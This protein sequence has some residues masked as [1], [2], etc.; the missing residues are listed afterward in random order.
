MG[1]WRPFNILLG[2]TN[3]I[4]IC[5]KKRTTLMK[6]T[7]LLGSFQGASAQDYVLLIHRDLLGLSS[8]RGLLRLLFLAPT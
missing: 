1:I 2:T 5:H 6:E 4:N 7:N 3:K 8:Q